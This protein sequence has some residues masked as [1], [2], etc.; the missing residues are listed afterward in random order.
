M[1]RELNQKWKDRFERFDKAEPYGGLSYKYPSEL[2]LLDKHSLWGFLFGPF[3]YLY[4]GLYTKGLL[5]FSLIFTYCLVL[6]AISY[7]FDISINDKIF[8]IP[9]EVV[10]A[11]FV[12]RDLYMLHKRS[13]AVWPQL[14]L[15]ESR[16][17]TAIVMVA[18]LS[19]LLYFVIEIEPEVNE[20]MVKNVSGNWGRVSDSLFVE[21]EL[22]GGDKHVKINDSSY[23]VR[24]KKLDVDSVILKNTSSPN[25]TNFSF[26]VAWDSSG[27]SFKLKWI[28]ERGSEII[29]DYYQ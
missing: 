14:K 1:K 18:S 2:K 7:L 4:K 11:M 29:L 25:P 21:L 16:I 20:V 8:S 5:L 6:S 17:A 10:C 26:H 12:N 28:R 9:G 13:E 27:E 23:K 22:Q 3:Y 15:F 19:S 24:V